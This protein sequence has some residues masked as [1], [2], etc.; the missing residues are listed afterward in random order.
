[1]N[2]DTTSTTPSPFATINGETFTDRRAREAR[3]AFEKVK[4]QAYQLKA[5]AEAAI[6]EAGLALA[7][8]KAYEAHVAEIENMN[9]IHDTDYNPTPYN[10][11][12]W[13]ECVLCH[14][15]IRD[16]PYGHNAQPLADGVC[17]SDCNRKVVRARL[18][19]YT[20]EELKA[21]DHLKQVGIIQGLEDPETK[22]T[23]RRMLNR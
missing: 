21:L 18:P 12:G 8:V 14:K 19:P 13:E 22:E 2:T 6:I 15:E 1:M 17:C 11:W 4:A 23:I 5:H 7:R 20:A 3:E 10:A 9:D 16:D